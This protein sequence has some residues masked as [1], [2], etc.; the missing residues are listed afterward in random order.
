MLGAEAPVP[1]VAEDQAAADVRR[2]RGDIYLSRWTAQGEQR[3]WTLSTTH[4]Q[5]TIGRSDSVDVRIEDDAQVSRV[6]AA[7]EYIGGQWSIRDDGLS[8]NGTFVNGRRVAS[9]VRLRDRDLIRVGHTI[10][11][12][13][14]PLESASVA[15]IADA[16]LPPINRLTQP[17]RLVL[18]ALC[19]PHRADRGYIPPAT[20]QQIAA[21]LCLSVDA[22][23][24]HLRLLYHKFGIEALP[25]NQKRARLAEIAEQL[26]LVSTAHDP[27]LVS[28]PPA[29]ESR[30]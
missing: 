8:S 1:D 21:E 23:K 14:A 4:G 5:V 26:G 22:V 3:R 16:G 25:Q 18:E 20:N 19:R 6:H 2:S 30:T 29:S 27:D 11:T 7:M 13:C 10:L 9:R 24:T 28:T 17:Q 12:F 15:T